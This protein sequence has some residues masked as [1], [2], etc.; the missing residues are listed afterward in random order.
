MSKLQIKKQ[1]A[2]NK[3]CW[4]FKAHWEEGKPWMVYVDGA[5]LPSEFMT[6]REAIHLAYALSISKKVELEVTFG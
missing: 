4:A 6:K 5:W 1:R 2:A 3:G